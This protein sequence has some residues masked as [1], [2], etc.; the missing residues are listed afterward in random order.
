MYETRR[1]SSSPAVGRLIA[2]LESEFDLLRLE[3][4]VADLQHRD[5]RLVEEID[6]LRRARVEL[7]SFTREGPPERGLMR[8]W[9][10]ALRIEGRIVWLKWRR[11]VLADEWRRCSAIAEDTRF[12]M[13]LSGVRSPR[14]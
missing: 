5:E 9:W 6:A 10:R 14:E 12:G 7:P 8:R 4:Y 3:R 2:D 1:R 11:G 13:R